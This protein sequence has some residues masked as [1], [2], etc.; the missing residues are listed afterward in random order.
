MEHIMR[1]SPQSPI[2]GTIKDS[3]ELAGVAAL[4]YLM[5]DSVAIHR[6]PAWTVFWLSLSGLV[7]WLTFYRRCIQLVQ[8]LIDSGRGWIAAH[9]SFGRR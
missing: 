6:E 9:D 4:L 8:Q 5:F 3:V 1:D 7:A 2:N